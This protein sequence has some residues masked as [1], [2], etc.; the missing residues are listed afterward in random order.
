MSNLAQAS[1]GTN[2]GRLLRRDGEETAGTAQKIFRAG[3]AKTL[4]TTVETRAQT[5]LPSSKDAK[6]LKLVE[7][8][9]FGSVP[10]A[11]LDSGAVPNVTAANVCSQ[12]HF[13]P[14]STNRRMKMSDGSEET[15][16]REIE[17]V[18]ITV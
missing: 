7:V 15:L 16:L 9:V 17:R 12:L 14:H 5:Q 13:Q 6:R 18:P 3:T 1:T 4:I 10:K 11:V 2:I 8:S